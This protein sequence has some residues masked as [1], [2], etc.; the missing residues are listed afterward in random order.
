MDSLLLLHHLHL[1]RITSSHLHQVGYPLHQALQECALPLC[2]QCSKVSNHHINNSSNSNQHLMM[3]LTHRQLCLALVEAVGETLRREITM[4]CLVVKK[5]VDYSSSLH[6]EL[7]TQPQEE[8]LPLYL[9]DFLE[10]TLLKKMISQL[11]RQAV[12]S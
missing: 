1:F 11:A 8:K 7:P 4:A 3:I 10:A 5:K 12:Q 9:M 2:H 6:Q